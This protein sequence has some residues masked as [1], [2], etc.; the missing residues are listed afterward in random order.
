MTDY[1]LLIDGQLVEGAGSMPVLNPATGEPFATAPKASMAQLNDAVAAARRAFPSWASTPVAERRAALLTAAARVDASSEALA[2]LLVQE[3]GMPLSNA[4]IEAMVFSAK[5]R[6]AAGR[7]LEPRTIAVQPGWQAQEILRPLGV[8]AAIM[9]WN[10][11]L[12][13]LGSKLGS[14]LMVGN[15]VVAKPAPTTPL[16][17]L[18]I[19]EIIAGVLPPGVLNIITDGNDLG[20]AL[21]SHPGVN[22]ISF[23]GST[24]TGRKIV[25][26]GASTV[27]R[28]LLEMG[29]ND[30]A[31]VLD[32]VDI[33]KVAEMLFQ[34]A[35]MNSGQ[36]CIAT[37]RIYA[38]KAIYDALCDQLGALA[39][40]AHTGDGM[41]EGVTLGPLQNRAQFERVKALL[42]EASGAATVAGQ[43]SVPEGAGFFVP[44]TILRDIDEASRVVTEE[45]FGPLLPVMPFE[46]VEDA[47]ERANSGVYGL[48]ASVFSQDLA[49]ARAIASRLD[50][51]T[52]TINKTVGFHPELPFGGA[53]QSGLGVDGGRHALAAYGQWQVVDGIEA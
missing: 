39:R 47:I 41:Q 16:T 40:Q 27:K 4:R 8:V 46:D 28:Y 29:G 7:P 43:G 25:A 37:K 19:G 5:L 20:E 35:F 53:K 45:Q 32:D 18:R 14:A 1:R 36:A 48:A 50:A 24:A 12:I 26:S 51:G 17:T 21:S 22:M 3:N 30:P 13:L 10:V 9:A 2:R 38:H 11:P 52:V 15:T 31:I 23:T 33:P 42:A 6:E 49:M 34:S 44:P